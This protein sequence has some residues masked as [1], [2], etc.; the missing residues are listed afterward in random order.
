M[1]SKG[2]SASVGFEMISLTG[3]GLEILLGRTEEEKESI[4]KDIEQVKTKKK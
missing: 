2:K 3:V 4:R 1:K